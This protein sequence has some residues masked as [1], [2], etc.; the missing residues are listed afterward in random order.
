MDLES[1][2]NPWQ[3]QGC[4]RK[5][6]CPVLERAGVCA[7]D[8]VASCHD[9]YP[10]LKSALEITGQVDSIVGLTIWRLRDHA[11]QFVDN[12]PRNTPADS[13]GGLSSLDSFAKTP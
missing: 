12:R 2:L 11:A 6:Y 3:L 10:Y 8:A 5:Y 1:S 9:C 13:H 4:I 7:Y